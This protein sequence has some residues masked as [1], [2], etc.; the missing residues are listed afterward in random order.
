MDDKYNS[1]EVQYELFAACVYMDD[2]EN[3]AAVVKRNID[4][5]KWTRYHWDYIT[6]L[7]E[8]YHEDIVP[9]ILFY[10]KKA[11]TEEQYL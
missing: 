10:Q 7:S 5:N 2:Y 11:K 9:H 4:D 6:D 1:K 3:Y 8:S